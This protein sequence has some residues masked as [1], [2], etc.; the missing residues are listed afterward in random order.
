[1]LNIR[2]IRFIPQSHGMGL[3]NVGWRYKVSSSHWLSPYPLWSLNY[4]SHAQAYQRHCALFRYRDR[5]DIV[6]CTVI[7]ALKNRHSSHVHMEWY[8]PCLV[9]Y[10]T[11]ITE[12]RVHQKKHI[13]NIN[14]FITLW[15]VFVLALKKQHLRFYT[16][17][18]LEKHGLIYWLRI[19]YDR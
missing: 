7:K 16:Q 14:A 12:K 1:M 10:K 18:K 9:S 4:E 3:A 15:M 5:Y 17:D 8:D 2:W 13:D 11:I 6:D 19:Q